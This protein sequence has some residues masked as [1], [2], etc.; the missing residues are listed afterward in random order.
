MIEIKK[1]SSRVA[2]I[3][4]LGIVGRYY[5]SENGHYLLICDPGSK[6][7]PGKV[8]L[9]SKGQVLCVVDDCERPDEGCVSNVGIFAFVDIFS[10]DKLGSGSKLYVYSADGELIFSRK[11]SNYPFGSGISS[12]GTHVVVQLAGSKRSKDGGR[13][14]LFNIP[15]SSVVSWFYPAEIDGGRLKCEFS[16]PERILYLSYNDKSF[17]RYKYSFDG[18]FLR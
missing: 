7:R 3:R 9:T 10:V 13:F 12:D 4:S 14:Y 1:I 17:K 6:G 18:S 5:E 8:A 16:V 11:F 15:S 2:S